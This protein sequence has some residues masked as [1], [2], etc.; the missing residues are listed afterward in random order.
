MKPLS[1][2][3]IFGL[4]FVIPTILLVLEE[5]SLHSDAFGQENKKE[6][7]MVLLSQRYSSIGLFADEIVEIVGEILNNGTATAKSVEISAICHDDQ[8]SIIGYESD[9]TNP[10]TINP[11][12]KSEFT[13]QILDQVIKSNTDSYEF[14]V[15]WQGE[16]S[17]HYFATLTG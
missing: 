9:R 10:S 17:S 3:E 6:F 2:I 8:G 14:T 1:N 13:I 15:K 11:G 4:V 5:T 16:Y 7:D 12:D